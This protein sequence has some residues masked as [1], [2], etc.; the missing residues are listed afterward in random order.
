MRAYLAIAILLLA[1]TLAGC[2]TLAKLMPG[3]VPTTSMTSLRV[4]A[5][6]GANMNAATALDIVF[7]YD[8]T[9]V[10]LLPK[11]GPA[12]FADKAALQSGLGQS[13]DVVSLQ[14]PPAMLIGAVKLPKRAGKALVV[15]GFANYLAKDGQARVD[16]TRYHRPV[17]WLAPTQ[18]TVTEP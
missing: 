11:T 5:Q 9:A 1:G 10:A 6:P 17:I 4:A 3:H 12:W 18:I 7:V 13:A 8:Q 15:Y 2:Q 14:V 16:L